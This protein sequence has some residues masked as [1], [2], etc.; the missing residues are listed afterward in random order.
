MQESLQPLR[1]QNKLTLCAC[2]IGTPRYASHSYPT[3][4]KTASPYHEAVSPFYAVN[5]SVDSSSSIF[6]HLN[7]L[8]LF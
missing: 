1:W 7:Q 4:L 6:D 5:D 2:R 3:S 8:E